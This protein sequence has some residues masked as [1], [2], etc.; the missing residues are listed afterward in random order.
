MLLLL[1]FPYSPSYYLTSLQVR[2]YKFCLCISVLIFIKMWCISPKFTLVVVVAVV[3]E[4]VIVVVVV[5]VGVA[6]NM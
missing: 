3:D 4:E 6:T 5:V 2:K 1:F